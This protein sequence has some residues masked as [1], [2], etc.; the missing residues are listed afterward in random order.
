MAEFDKEFFEKCMF[1]DK[2]YVSYEEAFALPEAK[3]YIQKIV[4]SAL[5][6]KKKGNFLDIGCAFGYYLKEASKTFNVFGVDASE[7]AIKKARKNLDCPKENLIACNAENLPFKN[8]FFDVIISIHSIEHIKN[9]KKVLKECN[10]TL[11][12]D[13][14]LVLDIPT[15]LFEFPHFLNPTKK[16][17][18]SINQFLKKIGLGNKIQFVFDKTHVSSPYPWTIAREKYLEL[19]FKAIEIEPENKFKQYFSSGFTIIAKPVK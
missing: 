12:K 11:K 13:G 6:Y 3:K 19:Y 15:K 5:K 18:F 8:N 4:G 17:V 2:G 9:Y 16:T 7:Y 1:K 10:R 14:I